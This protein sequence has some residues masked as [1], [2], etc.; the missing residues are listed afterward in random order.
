MKNA[1]LFFL[2]ILIF[3]ACTPAGG[4]TPINNPTITVKS[5][6]I[7]GLIEKLEFKVTGK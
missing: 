7:I 1:I 3:N 2:V 4:I 5:K 6:Y